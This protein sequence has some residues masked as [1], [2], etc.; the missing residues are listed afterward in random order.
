[1]K[2]RTRSPKPPREVA[3]GPTRV[4]RTLVVEQDI[5]A[6]NTGRRRLR[7][8]LTARLE[9]P[10]GTVTEVKRETIEDRSDDS[11]G[12][13]TGTRRTRTRRSKCGTRPTTGSRV[14]AW[15]LPSVAGL[16]EEG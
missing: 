13:S 3:K 9:A 16:P 2:K 15:L 8:H 4:R 5:S 6:D 11:P 1:M 7:E 10:N 14:G 12:F